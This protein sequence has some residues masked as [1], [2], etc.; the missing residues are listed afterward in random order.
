MAVF[1]KTYHRSSYPA[2]SPTL[3]Q[4]RQTGRTVLISGGSSGIGFGIAR[5]FVQASAQR[6]II[7]GRRADALSSAVEELQA[8]V[9]IASAPA[10]AVLSQT[11]D[12]ASKE[13]VRKLWA[14]LAS[15]DMPV[16][17][18]VLNAAHALQRTV[19]K[20][21]EAGLEGTVASFEVNVFSNL[22]MTS[23]FLQQGHDEGKVRCNS[24]FTCQRRAC[25]PQV[26]K[27]RRSCTSI[28]C[29]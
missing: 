1:T 28:R 26:R 6:V 24:R 16:D 19:L 4:N 25:I 9:P 5:A 8:E 11:C 17:I 22:R 15:N 29:C 20:D 18:L 13:D 3:A 21:M 10:T 2:I 27:L 7:L 12:V 23:S 14:W